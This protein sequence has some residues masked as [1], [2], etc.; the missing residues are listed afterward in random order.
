[1]NG[2]GTYIWANGNVYKGEYDNDK[3]QGFGNI[4]FT[5]GAS[6]EGTWKNGKAH[7]QGIFNMAG[8][9]RFAG[10]YKKGKRHGKGM[11][12]FPN[13]AILTGNWYNGFL[14]KEG[15]FKFN[16][17]DGFWANWKLGAQEG[18]VKY[19]HVSKRKFI[20]VKQNKLMEQLG[21]VERANMA[22]VYYFTATE[23]TFDKQYEK[24]INALETAT[25]LL[26][27]NDVRYDAIQMEL[28]TVKGLIK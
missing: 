28:L 13:G 6:Y 16:D 15:L 8:G 20:T 22:T 12:T 2:M 17:G 23:F 11:M 25:S 1:M 14:V 21:S 27:E 24:A 18:K 5:T 9:A 4:T 26:D 3:L 19:N 10:K 7:G